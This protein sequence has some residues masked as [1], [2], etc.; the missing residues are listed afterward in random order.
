MFKKVQ[1]MLQNQYIACIVMTTLRMAFQGSK[2][3]MQV[4][5]YQ[6][7]FIRTLMLSAFISFTHQFEMYTNYF[8]HVRNTFVLT[9]QSRHLA[10][11]DI[12]LPKGLL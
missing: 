12:S 8:T 1:L 6:N 2:L 5:I 3:E 7:N 9:I 4:H 11:E 10:I